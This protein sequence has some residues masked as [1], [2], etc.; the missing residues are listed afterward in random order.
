MTSPQFE[1]EIAQLAALRQAA[2]E[3]HQRTLCV[4]RAVENL[5][6][7]PKAEPFFFEENTHHES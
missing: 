7:Q 3:Y 5:H 1:A 6:L 4:K 2:E